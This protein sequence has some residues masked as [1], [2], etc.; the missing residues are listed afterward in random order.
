MGVYRIS[1]NIE[2]SLIEYI[3]A[4]LAVAGWNNI[5]VEKT[6]ARVYGLQMDENKG[7]A[8]ICVRASDTNRKRVE[9]GDDA[10]VRSEL[11]L[12]DVFATSDGQRLDLVDF[13]GDILKHGC[14]YY[15]H[16][17]TNGVNTVHT[18]NGRIRVLTMDDKPVNFSVE[19]SALEV[20]DRYRHLLSLTVSLG[21]VEV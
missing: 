8:A 12:I 20:Q 5:N 10:V 7:T 3:V 17:V 11:V 21:R 2:A 4:Q 13:L 9:I 16:T 1:R 19:K 15:E 18:Q 6:F 14:P